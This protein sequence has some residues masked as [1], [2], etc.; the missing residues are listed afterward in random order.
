MSYTLANLLTDI[1]TRIANETGTVT[2]VISTNYANESLRRLR[3]KFDF[4]SAEVITQTSIMSGVY[5][6]GLPYTGYKEFIA[7]RDNFAM[8]D[9]IFMR[10]VSEDVFWSQLQTGNTKSESRNGTARRLLFNLT[11]PP[12]ASAGV[13]AATGSATDGTWVA[14]GDANTVGTNT[15]YFRKGQGSTSFNITTST[16]TATITNSTQ[17]LKDLSGVAF[18]N[19]GLNTPWVF[20]PLFVGFTGMTFKWGSSATKYWTSTVTT[21]IDGSPFVTG[22][23][24]LGLDWQTATPIGSPT[25]TDAKSI[26][27]VQFSMTFP[28]SMP[29][30]TGILL[31]DIEIRQRRILNLHSTSDLLVIDGT[32]G[33]PKETFSS[34]TDS[35]SYLN[36]DASFIDFV[37]YDCLEQIFI[38]HIDDPSALKFYEMKRMELEQDLLMRFSSKRQPEMQAW[39]DTTTHDAWLRRGR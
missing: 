25:G 20:L 33:L 4:P 35:S 2:H 32:T 12:T 1:D 10:N 7:L 26:G 21:Q 37:L 15:L 23:N 28:L 14:S 11:T 5:F 22:W 9:T 36:I 6:Y 3:R 34:S 31:N 8:G 29:N 38:T 30:Q 13:N 18:L 27:Y 17:L 19:T 24:Q 16:G 39:Q